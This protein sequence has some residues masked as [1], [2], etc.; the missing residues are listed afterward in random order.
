MTAPEFFEKQKRLNQIDEDINYEDW[1]KY[2][3]EKDLPV[4]GDLMEAH[5]NKK[6]MRIRDL[7]D[8]LNLQS[9]VPTNR[10]T[11]DKTEKENKPTEIK[12]RFIKKSK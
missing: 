10:E 1:L 11:K 6:N 7:E 3:I 9:I 8:R 12:V 5:K 2:R 4:E